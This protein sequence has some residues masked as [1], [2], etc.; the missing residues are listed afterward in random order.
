MTARF[1]GRRSRAVRL[2]RFVPP[3]ITYAEKKTIALGGKRAEL[4]YMPIE[5][6]DDNSII[7]FFPDDDVDIRRGTSRSSIGCRSARSWAR[8]S[9]IK[10]RS[11]R[12]R[13]STSCR[14]HGHVGTRADLVAHRRYREEL[15]EAVAAGIAA[16]RTVEQLRQ[17]VTMDAYK[18]WEF[19]Q[20]WRADNVTGMYQILTAR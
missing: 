4:I 1:P 12:S 16:G 18:D 17:S 5:H 11:R 14:G 20:Q 13:S 3:D 10:E 9:E 15:R 6:A 8:R 7:L 2:R 19:Y